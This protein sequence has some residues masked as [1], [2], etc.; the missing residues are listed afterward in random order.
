MLKEVK[1]NA[2]AL[3]SMLFIWASIKD[4]EKISERFLD[5]LAHTPEMKGAFGP[6]FN[7]MSVRIVLSAISNRERLNGPTKKELRFWNYNMW[8]LEDEDMRDLML[9]PVKQ[10]NV[11]QAT[12]ET[13]ADFPYESVEVEF[14]PGHFET[15][16]QIDNKLFI[17]FFDVK[18]SVLDDMV[19]IEDKPLKEF[20]IEKIK[21]M[22]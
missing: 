7:E 6:D 21:E 20:V 10:L 22:K 16:K 3:E 17:N 9:T 18:A 8:M 14:F 15:V 19:T 12:S 13:S 11:D 2:K 4:R 5:Q 1:V